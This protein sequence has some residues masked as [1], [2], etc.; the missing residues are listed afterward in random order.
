MKKSDVTTLYTMEELLP[1]VGKLADEFTSKESSSVTYERARQL[2]N[3]VIYCIAHLETNEH[4]PAN[5]HVL[6]AEEAYQ[7]GYQAVIEKVKDTQKKYNELI[8]FF[9]SYENRNY[10]DT[11]EKGLPG[12]FLYYDAKFA[13]M[14][15]ILT[16]D[17]PIL[18]LDMTLEGIDMIRQY[19]DAI[20]DE[21]S[22]L[23]KFPRPYVISELR[24]FHPTYE[25]EFFN[26]QEILQLQMKADG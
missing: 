18:G 11:V 9:D 1:I 23:A 21:Q 19:I 24:S 3:A 10:R 15:T 12:F 2:M 4:L 25:R 6:P 14:D 8:T 13:P 20:W 16:L 22:Y 5:Q 26:L 17:Y 7:I